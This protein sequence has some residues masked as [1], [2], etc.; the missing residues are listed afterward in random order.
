M[1][2]KWESKEAVVG[3]SHGAQSESMLCLCLNGA[4]GQDL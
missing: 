3:F 4:R 2:G 1:F